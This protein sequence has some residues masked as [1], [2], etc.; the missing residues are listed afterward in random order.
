MPG[1]STFWRSKPPAGTALNLERPLAADRLIHFWPF[2]E[3]SGLPRDIVP[4]AKYRMNPTGTVGSPKYRSGG[5]YS[6]GTASTA[7]TIPASTMGFSSVDVFSWALGGIV[8]SF[9][10]NGNILD[11]G[12]GTGNTPAIRIGNDIGGSAANDATFGYD[13]F[14]P[15]V[16]AQANCIE[17]NKSF[18]IA[19]SRNGTGN[20]Y[21]AFKDGTEL[22]FQQADTGSFADSSAAKSFFSEGDGSKTFNGIIYYMAFWDRALLPDELERITTSPYDALF[23]APVFT[24]WFVPTAATGMPDGTRHMQPMQQGLPTGW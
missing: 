18:D 4:Q 2:N 5:V 7:Y 1:R 22:T 24:R 23:L 17:I 19:F 6:D 21:R 9:V 13:S 10:N 16:A 12:I 20:T 14:G 15:V 3:G 8:Y 11:C